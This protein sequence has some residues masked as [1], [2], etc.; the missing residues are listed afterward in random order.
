MHRQFPGRVELVKTTQPD[1]VRTY[2]DEI[3]SVFPDTWQAKTFG[4]RKRNRPRQLVCTG[5]VQRRMASPDIPF[6]AT[7]PIAYEV[8][9]QYNGPIMPRRSDTG[10]V[11]R[12]SGLVPPCG[13]L[14]FKTFSP[15]INQDLWTSGMGRQW[16]K[17]LANLSNDASGQLYIARSNRCG[18]LL[19]LQRWLSAVSER[20]RS[21]LIRMRLDRFVRRWLKHK[22]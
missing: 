15:K 12:T 1:R 22:R 20:G 5:D 14:S 11:T 4:H 9:W 13:I 8:G 3:D 7:S 21:L 18:C 17:D 10:R 2:L 19:T 6:C 16:K